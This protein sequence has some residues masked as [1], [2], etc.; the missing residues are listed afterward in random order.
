MKDKLTSIFNAILVRCVYRRFKDGK[1]G[2]I[3]TEGHYECF[4]RKP[5]ILLA[6]LYLLIKVDRKDLRWEFIDA[7]NELGTDYVNPNIYNFKQTKD[8]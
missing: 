1:G 7:A 3:M 8:E 5:L 2:Y 6:F 4:L